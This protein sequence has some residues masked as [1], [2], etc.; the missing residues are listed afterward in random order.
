VKLLI[1]FG[2]R[3]EVV[4]LASVVAA[5]REQ[6]H[7]VR[8]IATGQHRDPR[9]A[10][11]FFT[12]LAL[13]PDARWDLPPV[14]SARVGAV[15]SNA[16]QELAARPPDAVVVLG[17]THTVPLFGLAAR[18]A[19]VPVVHLEAGLRSF[20][21]RS[22]E[23]THRRTA[24][25]L[26]SLHLAPTALAATVLQAEGVDPRRIFVVGNPITDALARLGPP[27]RDVAERAGI[28]FTAHRATTVDD[29][30]RLSMLVECILALADDFGPVTFP[31]HP[32]TDERLRVAGYRD[33]LE[34]HRDVHLGRPLRYRAMLDAVAGARVV[35]TDSGG[36][37]EE[38]S[39]LGVPVVVLRESTCR[40]EGIRAGTTALVGLD[41]ERAVA[42]VARFSTPA[43]QARVAAVPC[44]YGDG[45]VGPRIARLLDEPATRALL[46][47]D[48]PD[49]SRSLP[50]VVAG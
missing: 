40:W 7:D 13:V 10:D 25:A 32:R 3:P 6:G 11:D 50:A 24:A 5:L 8:T 43:E 31:V 45:H 18:R 42:E 36:L 37:Q 4:K 22:L 35:V 15:L 9:L 14:E 23:E 28:V 30:E 17:D 20:N 49:F 16:Y 19:D 21:E 47:F 1:P 27:R 48:E 34:R 44:P 33:R 38:A 46:R 41:A 26:A 2:T 29:P 39:W 12:D